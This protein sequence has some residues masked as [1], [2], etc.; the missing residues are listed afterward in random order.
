MEGWDEWSGEA[1]NLSS[2]RVNSGV[3]MAKHSG[4]NTPSFTLYTLNRALVANNTIE[5]ST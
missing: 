1:L 3:F 5:N 4:K 2:V